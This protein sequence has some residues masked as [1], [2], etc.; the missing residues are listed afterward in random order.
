MRV[1][2]NLL[3]AAMATVP[4][5]TCSLEA[6]ESSSGGIHQMSTLETRSLES[7]FEPTVQDKLAPQNSSSFSSTPLSSTSSD[8]FKELSPFA[9]PTICG[10]KKSDILSLAE[11]QFKISELENRYASGQNSVS[12]NTYKSNSPTVYFN[13]YSKELEALSSALELSSSESILAFALGQTPVEG[14][15]ISSWVA[16]ETDQWTYFLKTV[17]KGERNLVFYKRDQLGNKQ[18]LKCSNQELF[19]LNDLLR[20]SHRKNSIRLARHMD[21]VQGS[22]F[23]CDGAEKNPLFFIGKTKQE[24]NSIFARKGVNIVS[25]GRS[26]RLGDYIYEFYF[27]EDDRISALTISPRVSG[28]WD[29]G[30]VEGKLLP[31]TEAVTTRAD[32]AQDLSRIGGDRF[33]ISDRIVKIS[34]DCLLGMGN[35]QGKIAVWS[36]FLVALPGEEFPSSRVESSFTSSDKTRFLLVNGKIVDFDRKR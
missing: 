31:Y 30:E 11:F 13:R 12:I 1:E 4:F 6:Q 22:Y 5:F 28:R 35:L 16:V 34:D 33:L 2:K 36:E 20:N 21:E 27:T 14:A 9:G 24:I 26:V 7:T 18:E 17:D 32:P 8:P 10:V 3:I 15:P 19:A 25:G 29:Q 23:Q